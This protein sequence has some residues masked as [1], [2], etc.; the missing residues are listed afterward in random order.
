VPEGA[1]DLGVRAGV[2]PPGVISGFQAASGC[3][4]A[5]QPVGALTPSS[6]ARLRGSIDLVS[7]PAERVRSLATPGLLVPLDRSQ[8]DGLG[9]IASRLRQLPADVFGGSTYALPYAW[10]PLALLSRDDA[11]PDGPPA[12]LRVL[13][14]PARAAMVAIPNDPLTLASAA[15]SV[16]VDDPFDL[17]VSDLGASAGLLRLS[18]VLYRWNTVAALEGLFDS[19]AVEVAIGPPRVA[20]ALRGSTAVTVT[21]AP[22]GAIGLAHTLALA[23]R[24]PHPVCA[25]RF[26][27]YILEPAVQA[28]IASVTRL[29]PVVPASCAALGR[30]A[31]ASLHASD[32]WRGRIQFARR[33]VAPALPWSRWVAAWRSLRQ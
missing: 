1:L 11:F 18:D 14:E 31:C 17:D 26:L 32:Q 33:P 5:Q 21:I 16:G 22:D 3:E 19:G 10:E 4:V 20:L 2:F 30:R 27:S 15:L 7:L 13:W 9:G 29:T 24:A 6:L 12:N 25:Y 8:I 23:A 28:A